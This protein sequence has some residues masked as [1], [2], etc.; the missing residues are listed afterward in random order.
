MIMTFPLSLIQ[1]RSLSRYNHHTACRLSCVKNCLQVLAI[2]L[3]PIDW[4]APYAVSRPP[5]LELLVANKMHAGHSILESPVCPGSTDVILPGRCCKFPVTTHVSAWATLCLSH[6][7]TTG[8]SAKP[9][10]KNMPSQLTSMRRGFHPP[11]RFTPQ[12]LWELHLSLPRWL[13]GSRL[14]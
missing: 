7:R 8:T 12:P 6:Q 3:N 4:K 11:R 1:A 14:E 9:R 2:G 13:W 5:S 10:S